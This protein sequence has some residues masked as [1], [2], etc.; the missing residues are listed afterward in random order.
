MTIEKKEKEIKNKEAEPDTNIIKETENEMKLDTKNIK[1]TEN[2]MKPD[3]KNIKETENEMKPDTKIIKETENEMKPDTK[4]VKEKEMNNITIEAPAMETEKDQENIINNISEY[5]RKRLEN[6]ERNR[7]I[8]IELIG[9][10]AFEATQTFVLDAAKRRSA[11]ERLRFH[12]DVRLEDLDDFKNRFLRR[13][14]R[15]RRRQSRRRRRR[16]RNH[17]HSTIRKLLMLLRV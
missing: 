9:E 8:L 7:K 10:T 12:L 13:L 5:E 3:T 17:Y 6:I 11:S 2:E 14:P 4:I 16:R 15:R 1:E